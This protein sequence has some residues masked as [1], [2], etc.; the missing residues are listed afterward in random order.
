[1]RH[2]FGEI[3]LPEYRSGWTNLS[4][5]WELRPVCRKCVIDDIKY[6]FVGLNPISGKFL[7]CVNVISVYVLQYCQQYMYRKSFQN[8]SSLLF[9][10]LEN[11]LERTNTKTISVVY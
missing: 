11:F 8:F 6:V 5:Q 4:G 2:K 7:T 3:D 9:S 1:M 10:K